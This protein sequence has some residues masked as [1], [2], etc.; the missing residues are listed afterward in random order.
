M[1]APAMRSTSRKALAGKPATC[2]K[3]F[4]NRSSATAATNFPSLTA[5]AEESGWK[6][7]NPRMSIRAG[8]LEHRAGS[9]SC[10]HCPVIPQ[11]VRAT[12]RARY[13]AGCSFRPARP[14]P[15]VA[16]SAF[17]SRRP[18]PAKPPKSQIGALPLPVL[19]IPIVNRLAESR[20]VRLI[21]RQFVVGNGGEGFP[22]ARPRLAPHG[23]ND[24]CV[25]L[26]RD[27][28]L[29]PQRTLLEQRRINRHQAG[30]R[31][32]NGFC[33]LDLSMPRSGA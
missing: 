15:P 8:S 6:A 22:P 25:P 28:H 27:I 16:A 32:R 19:A 18:D 7:F 13:S 10:D 29:V 21:A 26:S 5:Q 14:P 3:R 2:L 33:V 31:N 4:P 24:E 30:P 11:Q 9:S 1:V 20:Q 17:P 23:P 12:P